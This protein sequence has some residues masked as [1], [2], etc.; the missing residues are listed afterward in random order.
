MLQC[1]L[2]QTGYL[3]L[4]DV[5]LAKRKEIRLRSVWISVFIVPQNSGFVKVSKIKEGKMLFQDAGQAYHLAGGNAVL[6]AVWT[7]TRA[8]YSSRAETR[9]WWHANCAGRRLRPRC[10]VVEDLLRSSGRGRLPRPGFHR[11]WG[12][13]DA[14]QSG[15]DPEVRSNFW[16]IW[17]TSFHTR[18][19]VC[20]EVFT[21]WQG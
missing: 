1:A 3:R 17:K 11:G 14:E 6:C 13:A 9:S 20:K 8:M 19:N 7:S 18:M 12:S 15:C 10:S 5:Y 4:W 16:I 2:L 21:A